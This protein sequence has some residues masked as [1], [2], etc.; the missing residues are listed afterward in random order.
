MR[1]TGGYCAGIVT[2]GNCPASPVSASVK[3]NMTAV[4]ADLVGDLREQVF[5][6]ALVRLCGS[7]PDGVALV[8]HGLA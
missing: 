8:R 2:S 3:K 7:L 6:D 4:S 5:R 1:K